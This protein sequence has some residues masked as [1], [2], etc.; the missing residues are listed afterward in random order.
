MQPFPKSCPVCGGVHFAQQDVLWP[1]LISAWQLSADETTY[2]NR[3]QGLHCKECHNNLRAMALA[4]AIVSAFDFEGTLE[5]FC[6]PSR[7]LRI[8]E[9]NP[10]GNL[11]SVLRQ[12]PHYMLIEFPE[13]DMQHLVIE[14]ES[15]D[16]VVHSDT[17]EHV[18]NVERA[19]SECRRVL[20][21]NGRCIF[22]TPIVVDR[23]TRS[24][25]GLA[26]SYH[27][28]SGV[29]A[30]DQLVCTE[31]GADFWKMVIK[32]GFSTCEIFAF[33]YPA[34]LAVVAKN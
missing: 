11:S 16:L 8:L 31:F 4:A 34:A 21:K 3:Q 22:T 24:R 5:S 32:A 23:M 10:A 28:Q 17:L 2:V 33:E 12:L 7:K 26:S 30:N 1:D 20:A 25:T 19:L 15:Y 29:L 9:I 14:S 27:G 18:S 6:Q 13:F